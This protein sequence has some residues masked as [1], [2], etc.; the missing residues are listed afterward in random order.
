M[1]RVARHLFHFVLFVLWY[2]AITLTAML[3][4]GAVVPAAYHS[5]F[6]KGMVIGGGMVLSL[7][8][9]NAMQGRRSHR[10]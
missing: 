2:S 1:R 10:P 7:A 4:L 3:V 8:S 9:F 5:W 6:V